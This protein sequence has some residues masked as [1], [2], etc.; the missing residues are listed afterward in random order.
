MSSLGHQLLVFQSQASEADEVLRERM[1]FALNWACLLFCVSL[2]N[3]TLKGDL[4]ESVVVAFLAVAGI[5]V[6]K[7]IFKL[8]ANFTLL[9]LG[10]IKIGQML[11]M[12][13][14][15]VAVKEGDIAHPSDMLSKMHER[16]L[17]SLSPSPIG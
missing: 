5:D 13:R 2:I 3:H 7:R 16:L 17:T 8:P 11:V 1:Q 10:L 15:V 4:Y 9:L 6:K 12:Q 14:A